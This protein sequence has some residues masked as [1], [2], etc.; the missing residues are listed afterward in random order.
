MREATVNALLGLLVS[1]SSII[2]SESSSDLLAVSVVLSF[3]LVALIDQSIVS[4][5]LSGHP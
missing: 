3:G 5:D 4:L 2:Y 1:S